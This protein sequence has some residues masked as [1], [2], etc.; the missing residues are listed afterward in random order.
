MMPLLQEKK[1]QS[2]LTPG[3][4]GTAIGFAAGAAVVALSDK[5]NRKK[6]LDKAYELK[7][8]T[9]HVI[10]KMRTKA[11]EVKQTGQKTLEKQKQHAEKQLSENTK[12]ALGLQK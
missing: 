10:A 2:P 4:V 9:E 11:K 8:N 12:D 3:L 7:G 6:I 1:K 5:Q